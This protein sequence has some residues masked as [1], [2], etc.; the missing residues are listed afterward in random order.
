[1]GVNHSGGRVG[2]GFVSCCPLSFLAL[3]HIARK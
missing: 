3:K 2:Y 1:M